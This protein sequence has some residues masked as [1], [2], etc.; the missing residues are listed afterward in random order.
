MCIP[1]T[2]RKRFVDESVRLRSTVQIYNQRRRSRMI[3]TIAYDNYNS[4]CSLLAVRRCPGCNLVRG[5]YKKKKINLIRHTYRIVSLKFW[6]DTHRFFFHLFVYIR[7]KYSNNF[8]FD[9]F[10]FWSTKPKTSV[11]KN[12]QTV[13]GHL[14]CN[15]Y[16][17]LG[18]FSY[19]RHMRFAWHSRC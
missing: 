10:Y 2:R 16:V 8:L 14:T 18:N 9:I 4:S 19:S 17:Y 7:S 15:P 13:C 3:V 11:E 5:L 1:C 6:M 12:P